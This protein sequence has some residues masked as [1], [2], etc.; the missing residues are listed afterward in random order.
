[1]GLVGGKRLRKRRWGSKVITTATEDKDFTAFVLNRNLIDRDIPLGVVIDWI[2]ERY[3]PGDV[4]SAKVLG[5][6]EIGR[7]SCRERV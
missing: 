3:T 7:A 6:W 4:F 1:M 2:A 5:R